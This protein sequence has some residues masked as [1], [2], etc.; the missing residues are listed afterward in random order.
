LRSILVAGRPRD[1]QERRGRGRSSSWLIA[2][3]R[4]AELAAVA[5]AHKIARIAWKL[6]VSGDSYAGARLPEAS[7]SAA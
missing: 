1:Q 5:L 6:M 2:P 4:A 3:A 7:A